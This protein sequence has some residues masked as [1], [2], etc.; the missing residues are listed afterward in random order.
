MT[1]PRSPLTDHRKRR[2]IQRTLS[3]VLLGSVL[4]RTPVDA[5]T[6]H[7]DSSTGDNRRS[8]IVA[9]DAST[10]WKTLTHALKVAHVITDGRP[11]VINL[12]S[13]M[14][15]P[16]SGETF[17]FEI[18]QSGIYV[19]SPGGV[20]LD[21]QGLSRIF[22]ITAP[23][24]DFVLRDI[25]LLNGAADQGG[26]IYCETCSLRV[27]N[28][29]IIGNKATDAGEVIYVKDGRLKFL[30]NTVRVNGTTG[31]DRSL[32]SLHNT[33]S[34]TSQ[35]DVVRNN[36]FYLNNA[37]AVLTTGNRTD[38][39]S[40]IF[41]AESGDQIPAIIDSVS[42]DAPLVRY[43]LF[44]DVDI[45]Q[46]S[47]EKDST[48]VKRTIRD[49]LTLDDFGIS[50][51]SFV[52]NRPDTIAKVGSTY[53]YIIEV[54][55]DKSDYSF[56]RINTSDLPPE[57]ATADWQAGII[58]WT[59][60]STHVG[61]NALRV[62]IIHTPSGNLGL[63]S[64]VLEV[65]SEADFPDTTRVWPIVNVTFEA[66]TTGALG[67]LNS[68]VPTF[69]SAS[70]AGG[71][72]YADP[73]FLNT[74]TSNFQITSGSGAREAGNPIV[75]LRD[76]LTSGGGVRNDIGYTGGPSNGDAPAAGT[77]IEIGATALPDSLVV[78][79]TEWT[80]TPTLNE[81]KNIVLVDPVSGHDNP[82]GFA[83]ALT[84]GVREFPI[85]WTPTIADTGSWL[86]G[87][88]IFNGDGTNARHFIPVRVRPA[89]ESPRITSTAPT[90]AFEDSAF[91]YTVEILELDEDAVTFTLVSG[92]EG[93]TIDADGLVTWAPTQQ[94]TGSAPVEI[95]V[96]DE[97][98][99]SATQSF[100]LTVFNTNDA[101]SFVS[102]ADTS[103]A[104]DQL[105]TLQLSATDIDVADTSLTFTLTSGPDSL[106]VDSSGVVSWTPVQ[107]DVGANSVV[108]KVEDGQGGTDSTSFGITVIEVDDDP[109]IT[110]SADTTAPEDALYE[111]SV[112][113]TDEEGEALSFE[114]TT[115]PA[116][117]TIDTTG[118]IRWT[119]VQADT[120]SHDVTVQ[121][122]D[123]GGN[124]VSQ[125]F[126]ILVSAVNDAP[127]LVNRAPVDS[128][129]F[130]DPGQGIVFSV[131]ASDE[132]GDGLSFRWLVDGVV[133]SGETDD[134]FLHVPDTTTADTVVTR[135]LDGTDSTHV[136]WIV[137]ARAIPVALLGPDSIDFG[138]VTLGDS[139][140]A[141][142]SL[143]NPG[144][145]TLVISNLQ[146]GNLELTSV[147]SA[148]Q[149]L[150]DETQTLD[151]RYVAASRGA[152]STTISFDT[153]DPD[154]STVTIPV[155]GF[156]QI[157]TLV[158][159]DLDPSVGNQQAATGGG[160]AGDTI[161][162]D[163]YVT[164]A[165]SVIQATVDLTFDPAVLQVAGF[166][167]EGADG[168]NLLTEAT[169]TVTNSTAGQVRI[170]VSTDTT[171]GA[172]DE[173]SSGDGALGRLLLVIDS[174]AA[175][176]TET[177][178]VI[179]TAQ[180]LSE[181][182]GTPDTLQIQAVSVVRVR[183]PLPTDL[184]DDGIVDI[185]DFFAFA[186]L[187][188]TTDAR[189]DFNNSGGIVDLDDF[190]FFAD[191]FGASARPVALTNDSGLDGLILSTEDRPSAT[192]FVEATLRWTGEPPLRGLATVVEFDPSQLRFMGVHDQP[193]TAASLLWSR[194]LRPGS[195]ELAFAR[196]IDQE[197]FA[198]DMPTLRFER[199]YPGAMTL[200][201][202]DALGHAGTDRALSIA[203]PEHV[204]V[205]A[206]PVE[207]VLYPAYPNPFNPETTIS[208]FVPE[209]LESQRVRVRIFDLL[210]QPIRTLVDETRT[211][212][213]HGLVWR[214][215]D[216]RSQPVAAGVYL[217]ELLT[218][219]ER[220]VRKALYLK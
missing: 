101:P 42:G 169:A 168:A 9:Q 219:T 171:A 49:T 153:N 161:G 203:A 10:P 73:L 99:E 218:G 137:D 12:T 181:G 83:D 20:L 98:G 91:S 112:I 75:G 178:V 148:S 167:T 213:H 164:E 177:E 130:F 6:F 217:I 126:T 47:E 192:D 19:S 170:E 186:D 128:F 70:S 210:G 3:L 135:I 13:G 46:L 44:W 41:F 78:Q 146:V 5:L 24:S 182:F 29:R 15:S 95:L 7:V 159:L 85:T 198:L 45:L 180:L 205:D 209:T 165:I 18:T 125:A 121:V 202:G 60:D 196:G 79:G 145:T 179:Q 38:I 56:N 17:P 194:D 173:G 31:S 193:G 172:T 142:L 188:G 133:Q 52:T 80:Y 76:A 162:V 150:E 89:N 106:L 199:L 21:A 149:V 4:W 100:A 156:G 65:F 105:F 81:E 103:T 67:T 109:I 36:T 57:V 33:F 124:V 208:F 201:L 82:P 50:L 151:V 30:N 166:E 190:F 132:E 183:S 97:G 107:T 35:R 64:Y 2:M 68:I 88:Q 200:R 23:T 113:A 8:H 72:V 59:P 187:Y 1:C 96:T 77:T 86:L 207:F 108:V 16:S 211:A 154:R 216:E 53:E 144:R 92:P 61:N 143:S 158:S 147:F 22:T 123:P 27:A 69:S 134:Q 63:A 110:S 136:Q 54:D 152:L 212:G 157:S 55:G 122:S 48:K 138:T 140:S 94:D 87:L 129:F 104:E 155:S 111:Y 40:N 14:Y 102:I 191:T 139:A 184:N 141:T 58:R 120:G 34:D 215:R 174:G 116:S 220:I 26:A 37:P 28:T 74:A 185:D 39:S 214:G 117:M 90:Q 160:P 71:N 84:P 62:E 204:T 43:N 66:D 127:V 131:S 51:P 176:D 115:S 25:A 206:L 118:T 11:H 175:S 163:I 32:L 93:M 195:I 197:A 119:P 189:G 114:L